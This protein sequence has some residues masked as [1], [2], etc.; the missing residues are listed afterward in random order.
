MI[1]GAEGE[2]ITSTTIRP[3][4]GG[5]FRWE[6]SMK[7]FIF[8]LI[9]M[10]FV[11]V[12]LI[13]CGGGSSGGI[14]DLSM[15]DLEGSWFGPNPTG[16][17]I[18]FVFDEFGQMADLLT[19]GSSMGISGTV[20][21]VD[22]NYFHLEIPSFASGGLFVDGLAKYSLLYLDTGPTLLLEK[23]ATSFPTYAD[24][25]VVGSWS[26]FAYAYS[27]TLGEMVSNSPVT[28]TITD[29]VL[30]FAVSGSSAGEPMLGVINVIDLSVGV[31]LMDF[32]LDGLIYT[33]GGYLSPDKNCLG[34]ASYSGSASIY[35][36]DYHFILLTRD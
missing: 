3:P 13:A 11:M 14:Q 8:V 32:S 10:T 9:A 1:L 27:D 19:N 33:G 34:F 36:D 29:N 22:N 25:D 24:D 7:R 5:L 2:S 23:G 6:E 30:M 4:A 26:G 21:Q 35:P 17:S 15:A 18:N 20:D 28:A 31:Y 12:L 16:D